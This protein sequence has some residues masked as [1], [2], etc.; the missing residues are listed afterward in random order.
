MMKAWPIL[1]LLAMI[2]GCGAQDPA[3][4]PTATAATDPAKTALAEKTSAEP[5]SPDELARRE[6]DAEVVTFKKW[7]DTNY[8]MG[9]TALNQ[10]RQ[11][12]EPVAMTGSESSWPLDKH[13]AF[14]K[15]LKRQAGP[16]PEEGVARLRK[17]CDEGAARYK[18]LADHPYGQKHPWELPKKPEFDVDF[19]VKQHQQRANNY[20]KSHLETLSKVDRYAAQEIDTGIPV[21][22]EERAARAAHDADKKRVGSLRFDIKHHAEGMGPVWNSNEIETRNLRKWIPIAKD[23]QKRYA[24]TKLFDPQSI[25][26]LRAE[27]RE[28]DEAIQ[29]LKVSCERFGEKIPYGFPDPASYDAVALIDAEAKR[30]GNDKILENLDKS[31]AF[32]SP[33]AV[34]MV[35]EG[36]SADEIIPA[37]E[38]ERQEQLD[39]LLAERKKIMESWQETQQQ[40]EAATTLDEMKTTVAAAK[41]LYDERLQPNTRAI[42]SW[43]ARTD[44]LGFAELEKQGILPRESIPLN[45]MM[46]RLRTVEQKKL[47]VSDPAVRAKFEPLK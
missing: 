39:K 9:L 10:P 30:R 26:R 46:I 15:V 24:E 34:A 35:K 43:R 22:A 28:L 27:C 8:G 12:G 2:C 6:F 44:Y 23:Y 25:A 16:P 3:P 5:A 32:Y 7:V 13:I 17:M 45:S 18:K 41:R 29:R 33:L 1:F 4:A 40:F 37:V 11:P 14:V 19:L 38:K 36:K 31:M 20:Y 21:P 47:D 42:D